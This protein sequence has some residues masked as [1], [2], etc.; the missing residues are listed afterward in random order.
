MEDFVAKITDR[1]SVIAIWN[2][3]LNYYV[4]SYLIVEEG[5]NI[6]VDSGDIGCIDLFKKYVNEQGV[7]LSDNNYLVL[8]H[9]H[10]DHAGAIS[11]FKPQMVFMNALDM[12]II[13]SEYNNYI[14]TDIDECEKITGLELYHVG[15]HTKGSIVVYY[16]KEKILFL[17]DFVCFFGDPIP[18]DGYI[19]GSDEIQESELDFYTK[20]AKDE[21]FRKDTKFENY[22]KYIEGIHKISLLE[23]DKICS[24]HGPVLIKNANRFIGKLKEIAIITK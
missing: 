10:Y 4:N 24:G 1:V 5:K 3:K 13:P 9:G 8:T 7:S 22:S 21:K 6:F 12:E 19:T 15:H 11:V 17:G 16:K 18:S 14:N 2:S 20:I 23:V